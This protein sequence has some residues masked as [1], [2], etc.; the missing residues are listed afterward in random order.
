MFLC[1]SVF[2]IKKEEREYTLLY[3]ELHLWEI[4]GK[5]AEKNS[6]RWGKVWRWMG[7][8]IVLLISSRM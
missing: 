1:D 4:P 8:G 7:R 6:F 5:E 3:I 2:N